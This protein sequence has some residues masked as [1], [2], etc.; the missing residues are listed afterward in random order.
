[1]IWIVSGPSSCGK[2]SF[3]RSPRALEIT[4]LT[5]DQEVIF[6]FQKLDKLMRSARGAFFHY[7]IC[8]P[9]WI[10]ARKRPLVYLSLI[11]PSLP[12]WKILDNSAYDFINEKWDY[13]I[14]PKWMRFLSLE[15]QK[16]AVVLVADKNTLLRRV[17]ERKK[18][19][20]ELGTTGA[21][22]KDYPRDHWAFVYSFLDMPLIYGL[23]CKELA[24]A[25][26]SFTLLD[27]ETFEDLHGYVLCQ[28]PR[29][30]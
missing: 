18:R 16:K 24:R 20:D 17:L 15:H 4:G 13:R 19:E 9:L 2:S 27:S 26:I 10:I 21:R 29:N 7:N 5:H 8:R 12:F 1:M 30:D 22:K 28:A 14:D 11:Y 3:I 23:W 25:G 6:P